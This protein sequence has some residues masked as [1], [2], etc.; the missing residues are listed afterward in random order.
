MLAL[1]FAIKIAFRVHTTVQATAAANVLQ[2]LLTTSHI[3]VLQATSL[4]LGRAL[5]ETTSMD[6]GALEKCSTLGSLG[7]DVVSRMSGHSG[8]Q[9]EEANGNS[10][11]ELNHDAHFSSYIYSFR[12]RKDDSWGM[13]PFGPG[14]RGFFI[15]HN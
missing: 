8:G 6:V 4:E 2:C 7:L 5:G 10:G 13:I 9:A 11:L 14:G 15:L 3:L 1:K 12:T